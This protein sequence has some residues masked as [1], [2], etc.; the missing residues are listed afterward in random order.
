L[1][2]TVPERAQFKFTLDP[3]DHGWIGPVTRRD[4]TYTNLGPGFYR[5]RVITNN[6]DGSWNSSEAAIG[7]E[8]DAVFW[9]AWWFR[10]AVVLGSV[11]AILLL[12]RF[13]LRQLTSRLNVRFEERLAE[14]TRI[15]QELHDTLLQGFLSASMQLHVAVDRLPDESPAR[16]SFGRILDLMS[17]VIEEGRNAVQGLRSSPSGSLNLEQ[18]LSRIQQE[19][20]LDTGMGFCM[21]VEGRPRPLH[22]VL[23]DEVY[24]ISR[25]A[26]VNAFRHS[27]ARKIE[28]QLE[29]G[30]NR[31]RIQV[32]D[33]GC[34]IDPE[35]LR[36]GRDGHWGLPGMRE[37]A[38]RIGAKLHVFSSA[39]AGTEVEL[40]VPSHIAFQSQ[41]SSR[42]TVWLSKL[43]PRKG[44]R[45][46]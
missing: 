46:K 36:T 14:R 45:E 25:E 29:Y 40:S 38:D 5:F 34:G 23:R 12:Y 27:R 10:L 43:Y 11:L 15:A 24:R 19:L 39:A 41:P 17:R 8:I 26:V 7:F 20:A 31:L 33:D 16:P 4:A 30:F 32:R 9:Q 22:P 21:I 35:V 3:F 13:R 1:N 2:L 44:A 28:V 42:M 37:R 18:A 6:T